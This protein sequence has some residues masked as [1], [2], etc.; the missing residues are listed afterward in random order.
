MLVRQFFVRIKERV[1]CRDN[2]PS[3]CRVGQLTVKSTHNYIDYRMKQDIRSN[4]DLCGAAGVGRVGR[5]RR[6]G[7]RGLYGRFTALALMLDTGLS[8]YGA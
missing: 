4:I 5:E 3:I 1:G 2:L 8:G 6:C 7:V